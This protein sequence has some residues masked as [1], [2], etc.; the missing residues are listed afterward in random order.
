MEWPYWERARSSST[1]YSEWLCPAPPIHPFRLTYP[2]FKRDKAWPYGE[3]PCLGEWIFLLPSISTFDQFPAL[4][5][6]ARNGATLLDV[7]CC[8]GQN[9]RLFATH[10]VPTENMYALDISSELWY[11]GFELFRDLGRMKAN[12]I[13]ADF[14]NA[15]EQLMKLT[16]SIDIVIAAQFLHLF[17]WNGQLKAVKKIVSLSKPGTVLIGYQQAR[18]TAREYVRPW[19]MMYY[20]NLESFQRLWQEV[21]YETGTWWKVEADLVE[22]QEWGMED[23]DVEWMP[24]D[25]KGINFVVTRER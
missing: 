1:Q 17:S 18:L 8:F 5:D 25:R 22:L 2:A 10:G 9:L 14:L 6:Q 23:E 20:H 16:G 19:G 7:G 13:Q 3:Y 12:F 15:D 11:L 21:G 24:W 4:L